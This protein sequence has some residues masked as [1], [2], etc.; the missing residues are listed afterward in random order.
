[1]AGSAS[2]YSVP[3]IPNK[4]IQISPT[5]NTNW[6]E[7]PHGRKSSHVPVTTFLPT[8][9]QQLPSAACWNW[10]GITERSHI[11]SLFSL[12]SDSM[13]SPL[14]DSKVYIPPY[15]ASIFWDNKMRQANTLWVHDAGEQPCAPFPWTKTTSWDY[16]N[17][18]KLIET[19]AYCRAFMI[20]GNSMGIKVNSSFTS[21]VAWGMQGREFIAVFN[22]KKCKELQSQNS[23]VILFWPLTMYLAFRSIKF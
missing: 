8:C 7:I 6:P 9:S 17:F 13:V 18:S 19:Y 12:L 2:G 20:G 5:L 11:L 16:V 23:S 21:I 22:G 15:Y 14:S 10:G 3:N 1:M 4:E